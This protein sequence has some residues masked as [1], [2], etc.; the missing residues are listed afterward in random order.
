MVNYLYDLTRIEG[1]HDRF[2][3]GAVV[4][5]RAISALL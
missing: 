5:S 1:H 4:A 2:A 3:Q